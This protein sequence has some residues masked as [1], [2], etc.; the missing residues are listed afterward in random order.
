LGKNFSSNISKQPLQ[1]DQND[2]VFFKTPNF[3][4]IFL[5]AF[6]RVLKNKDRFWQ[7]HRGE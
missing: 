6:K 4:C 1:I 7:T 5:D 3:F 2:A